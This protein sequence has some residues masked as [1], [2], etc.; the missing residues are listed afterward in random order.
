MTVTT[1]EDAGEPAP[2]S[3]VEVEQTEPASRPGG[4]SLAHVPAL[5]GLRGVAVASVLLYHATHLTGSWLGD[6]HLTGGWLGVDLFFVLSGYLITGLLLAGWRR[7]HAV[8]LASFW[9][10]RARRLAP[11]L[12]I[13]LVAVGA[14]AAFVG[15]PTERLGIRNDGFATLFEV[16]NWRAVFTSHDYFALGLRPSPLNHTWSLAIEEQVYLVWPLLVAGL[17]AWRRRAR[18]VLTA[19]LVGA[20]VSAT[21]MIA[22]HAHGDSIIRLYDGTDTRACA[23]LLGAAVAAMR[24]VLG[25][26]RWASTRAVRQVLGLV[27]AVGLGWAWLRL[28]GATDLPYE[29]LLPLCSLAGA[30]VVASVTDRHRP[31]P[32]GT[33]LSLAPLRWLGLISYGVYLYHWPIF[34][35][36]DQGRTGLDGWSLLGLQVAVTIGLAT[37]SYVFVEQPIRTRRVFDQRQARAALPAGVAIAAIALF[38]GTLGA[39]NEPAYSAQVSNIIAR[40]SVPGA[41]VVMMVGDSVP[42]SLGIQMTIQRDALGVSVADRALAGCHPLASLGPIR[43]SAGNVRTDVHDCTAAGRYRLQVQAVHP[44]VSVVMFGEFPNEA[45]Q[46]RGYWVKPCQSGYLNA[47]HD[48]LELLIDDLRVEHAPVVLLTAPGSSLSWVVE[49]N[50]PGMADRVACVNNV[51]YDIARHRPGVSVVD[52]AGLVCPPYLNKCLLRIDGANLRPD[53]LHFQ[54]AGAEYVNKWLVPKILAAIKRG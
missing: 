27:A 28:D 6:D 1:V 29:G 44:S 31:G 49:R 19:A 17:L 22:L 33:I 10:R 47:L 40:S 37:W 21:L 9:A 34:L 52:L 4:P 30:C 13:T 23:V 43:G 35:V 7:D 54:G 5:D 20:A 14:Y 39:I 50:P 42:L 3:D 15:L 12:V 8:G 26:D 16:A 48:R 11:A 51:L 53:G 24:I 41:P 38:A 36:L 18:A 45:V 32:L 25:P 46:I 2:P